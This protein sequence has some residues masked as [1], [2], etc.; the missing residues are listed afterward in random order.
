MFSEGSKLVTVWCDRAS[1]P[2]GQTVVLSS[3]WYSCPGPILVRQSV[4]TARP[5]APLGLGLGSSVLER[6]Q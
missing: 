2:L 4:G 3:A 1:V 6:L 5:D